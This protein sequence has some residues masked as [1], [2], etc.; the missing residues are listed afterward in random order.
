[1]RHLGVCVCTGTFESLPILVL[2][3]AQG[4]LNHPVVTLTSLEITH[5]LWKSKIHYRAHKSQPPVPIL[6]L[7]NPIHTLQPVYLRSIL[8]LSS[9]LRLGLPSGLFP[10]PFPTKSLYAFLISRMRA[11]CP[12][13]LIL[14]DF[15]ILIIFGEDYTLWSSWL[16]S[17]LQPPVTS[18]LLGP[19]IFLSTLFSNTLNLCSSLN[20]RDQISHAYENPSPP[21]LKRFPL[22]NAAL[23]YLQIKYIC[24]RYEYCNNA[25]RL[26][27]KNCCLDIMC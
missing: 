3:G 1:V 5:L 22:Y 23:Y 24:A 8:I 19:N 7:M 12:T 10:S 25:N 4:L 20:M 15:I 26:L 16:C 11:T 13:C 18:S 9:H 21:I 6:S 14:L 2:A 17:F 27:Q